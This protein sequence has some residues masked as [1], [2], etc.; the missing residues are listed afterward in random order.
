MSEAIK[1]PDYTPADVA[2]TFLPDMQ[3]NDG[4][5]G[6]TTI[7]CLVGRPC[8]ATSH[9]DNRLTVQCINP[10]CSRCGS[11]SISASVLKTIAA[12]WNEDRVKEVNP[13]LLDAA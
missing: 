3:W 6:R 4:H 13:E 2:K 11:W 12:K 10:H 8:H 1:K 9:Y 7:D 5:F